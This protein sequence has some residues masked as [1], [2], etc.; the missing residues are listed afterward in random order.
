MGRGL[1]VWTHLIEPSEALLELLEGGMLVAAMSWLGAR[2]S[3][4]LLIDVSCGRRRKGKDD[5]KNALEPRMYE[6]IVA[7]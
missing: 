4:W 7:E 1:E 3:C 5:S 6:S 2:M